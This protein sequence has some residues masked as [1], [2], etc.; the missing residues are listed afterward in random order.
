MST[1]ATKLNNYVFPKL[2]THEKKPLITQMWADAHAARRCLRY[3]QTCFAA[4]LELP[5]LF[6]KS[7]SNAKAAAK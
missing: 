5:T 2:Q 1:E 6:S 7:K 4:A 3:A